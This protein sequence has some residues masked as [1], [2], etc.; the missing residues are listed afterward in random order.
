ML[1]PMIP[2]PMMTMRAFAG[3]FTVAQFLCKRN[4]SGSQST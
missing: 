1:Q 3:R 2:P 4:I